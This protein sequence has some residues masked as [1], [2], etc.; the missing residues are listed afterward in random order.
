MQLRRGHRARSLAAC[1]TGRQLAHPFKALDVHQ[2]GL[3]CI[4]SARTLCR[5]AFAAAGYCTACVSELCLV[6][7]RQA[8][9]RARDAEEDGAAPSLG[10]QLGGHASDD[11]EDGSDDGDGNPASPSEGSEGGE[12]ATY[13]DDESSGGGAS[14]DGGEV[15]MLQ[16]SDDEGDPRARS[17][18]GVKRGASRV[19]PEPSHAGMALAGKRTRMERS[20]KGAGELDGLSVQEQ[21]ALALRMLRTR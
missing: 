9:K 5:A 2:R 8:R 7:A 19:A 16:S 6:R 17:R 21:E 20:D 12:G 11:D 1:H 18:V 15:D 10:A 14:E 4:V 13:G 3:N